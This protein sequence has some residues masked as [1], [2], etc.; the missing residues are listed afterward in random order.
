VSVTAA[1][2]DLPFERKLKVALLLVTL[3]AIVPASAAFLTYQWFS[4]QKVFSRQVEM[5]AQVVG[6]QTCAALEFRQAP[7]AEGILRT[8]RAERQIESAALYD[9]EGRLFARF[10]RDGEQQVP[11]RCLGLGT[12]REGRDLL[13][14]RPILHGSDPVGSIF[15]RSDMSGA[16]D[17]LKEDALTVVLVLCA[18]GLSAVWL[19]NPL[20]NFLIRPIA[21]LAEAVE[22]VSKAQDYSVRVRGPESRDE[23]GRLLLRFNDMIAELQKRDVALGRARS[24]LEERVE[25]RTRELEL[26]NR[27]LERFSYSV[28]HDLKAPLRSIDGYNRILLEDYA[29]ELC[30][31]ARV[32]LE[33]SVAAAGRMGRLI[34]D[35]LQLARISRAELSSRPVNLSELAR[36][37]CEELRERD[38]KR[39]IACEIEPNLKAEGDPALL[40]VVFQNLMDNAW[41]FT[42][43]QARA[44][45][46]VGRKD[47]AF[48]VSDD[49]AG[50]DM[51]Y[52]HKLFRPF[53]RLHAGQDYPGTGI[54][55]ATVRRVIE[56]HGGRVWAVGEPG[57][58]ATFYFTLW[59]GAAR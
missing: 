47:D 51:A 9:V 8:L 49:G 12:D 6:D 53:E 18:A 36:E 54:G 52:E 37:V 39:Q 27:E 11:P 7:Q 22:T 31:E 20:G 32:Y 15:L 30:P 25:N 33:R 55:L 14:V 46:R 24:E 34:D 19:S 42:R 43:R 5:L 48:Y 4:L 26:A 44:T 41:K 10:L 29:P 3:A 35:F 16:W 59:T 45:V 38:P 17:R 28:S 1:V 57:R 21:R 50:F 2:R 23:I 13:V 40:R 58:G 56:R